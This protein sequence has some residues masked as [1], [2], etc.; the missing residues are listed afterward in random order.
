MASYVRRA[1]DL[2]GSQVR[3]V[4]VPPEAAEE[5]RSIARQELDSFIE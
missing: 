1:L 4:H 3:L 5:H 2:F